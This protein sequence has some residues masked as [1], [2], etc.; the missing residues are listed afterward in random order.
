M[1]FRWHR[2]ERGEGREETFKSTTHIMEN[3]ALI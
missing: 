1:P 2:R 3:M